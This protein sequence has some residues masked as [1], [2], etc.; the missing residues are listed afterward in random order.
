M[1]G[2]W[3]WG[4]KVN[5]GGSSQGMVLVDAVTLGPYSGSKTDGFDNAPFLLVPLAAAT[6]LHCKNVRV[7]WLK[8]PEKLEKSFIKKHGYKPSQRV[9]VIEIAP[10]TRLL[11]AADGSVESKY[12]RQLQYAVDLSAALQNIY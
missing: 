4:V 2:S 5:P 12:R 11:P 9:G 10:M 1:M 7:S 6:F 8:R 3:A